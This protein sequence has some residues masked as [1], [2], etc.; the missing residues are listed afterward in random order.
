MF[1]LWTGF[2]RIYDDYN[3][4]QGENTR[5]HK[6]RMAQIEQQS[7]SNNEHLE[8]MR[9]TRER[10]RV[11]AQQHELMMRLMHQQFQKNA[12]APEKPPQ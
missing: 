5:A 9:Q 11:Q 8:R 3:A 4:Q 12:K 2:R 7:R 6:R 10:G 1:G